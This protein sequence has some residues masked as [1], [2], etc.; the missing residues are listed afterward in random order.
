MIKEADE[1]TPNNKF[2]I[3]TLESSHSAFA[4]M[5][6]KLAETLASLG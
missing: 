6:D 4:S 5:P 1:F 2:D 3:K